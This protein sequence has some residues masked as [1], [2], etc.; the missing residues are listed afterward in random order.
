MK[1]EEGEY[2][3]KAKADRGSTYREVRWQDN[4]EKFSSPKSIRIYPP[5]SWRARSLCTSSGGHHQ[6][7]ERGSDIPIGATRGC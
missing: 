2:E 6:Q 1:G 7:D 4:R 3:R 5:S